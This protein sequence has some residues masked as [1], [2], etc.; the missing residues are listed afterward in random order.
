MSGMKRRQFVTLLGS[1]AAWPLAARAQQSQRVRRIGALMLISE[2]DP[3]AEGHIASFRQRL[4]E[5][6]WV[7]GRNVLIDVR[8]GAGDSASFR[9]S[10]AELAA[11]AP[12]VVLASG[13]APVVALKE[14]SS[15][16]PIVFVAVVDPVGAG[17]VASL[18]QPRGNAT[19][20]TLFEYAIAAKWLELLK[21][22]APGV[23]RVA[24]LRDSTT[25]A[26]IGQFAAI[27]T[28]AAMGIQLSVVGLQEVGEIERDITQFARGS[29]GGLIV[30]ASPFG[31]NHPDL[32][33]RLAARHKLPAVYPFRYFVASG[34]LI[35]YGPDFVGQFRQAAGYVDRILKGEKPAD[36]PV[37]AP[38]KYDLVINLKTAKA[39]GLDVPPMLLA[40]ADEVIE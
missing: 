2:A 37:Q 1:A 33:A 18:A 25:A 36:L 17:F 23:M 7:D 20:F 14:I 26:G 9:R 27:Q 19:G 13:G 10:A 32:I 5:L 30:T 31:A 21:E 4:Q 22:I 39:L 24:V 8:W 29:N 6:G 40:R 15:I 28:V 11:L 38:T 3:R 12:D 35:S 34:G 16:M